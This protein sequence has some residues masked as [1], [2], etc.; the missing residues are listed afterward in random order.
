MPDAHSGYGLPI[1]G[2]LATENAVI[3]FGVGL[4]IGCRMSLSLYDV[5]ADFIKH[6]HY[7][8][9]IALKEQTHFGIGTKQDTYEA[10]E[11]LDRPEFRE[12][13]ILKKLHGKAKS[14]IG[15]SGSGNHFVEVGVVEL[16]EQNKFQM[17][18]GQYVG[19]LAHSGSRDWV[20]GLLTI[21]P[22]LLLKSAGCPRVQSTLH[23]ST[24]IPKKGRNTGWR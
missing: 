13:G 9:K 18:A 6:N 15:T 10:H 11:V 19:I 17:P 24:W 1:G 2:V 7:Q 3:P 5:P 12:I 23:G 21:I 14:Q 8:V 22:V 16:D 4:D 20:L